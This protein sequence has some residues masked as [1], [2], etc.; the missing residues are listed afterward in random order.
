MPTRRART[1]GE[2]CLG[3]TRPCAAPAVCPNCQPYS[4]AIGVA[5]A[6]SSEL[7][8]DALVQ[9]NC[10]TG[11]GQ[12]WPVGHTGTVPIATH[13]RFNSVAESID[14]AACREF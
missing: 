10:P 1:S 4:C 11:G 14:W 3:Q 12:L 13:T 9:L 6:Y 8:D 2:E 7:S 5:A